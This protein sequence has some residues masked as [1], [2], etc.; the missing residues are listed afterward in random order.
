MTPSKNLLFFTV[1]FSW[2]AR[3]TL[4][5]ILNNKSQKKKL[6]ETKQAEASR[7][8]EL[9][10]AK[11]KLFTY[12]THE[13]RTPLT[14]ILGMTR[15]IREK[16]E[17]WLESGTEKI[18]NN[19][20]NP[21]NLVNQMLDLAKLEAGAMPLHIY[22]QDIIM[23]LRYLT[24]SFSSLAISRN[25]Q[26]RFKP[27]TDHFLLDYD[28]DK[29]MHIVSNLLSNALKF[30]QEG[31]IVELKAGVAANEKKEFIIIVTDNGSGI[32]PEHLPHIFDRFY[33]IEEESGQY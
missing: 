5:L 14:I 20:K 22:Q 12:I 31:N 32:N 9:D 26:L 25:I 4:L 30:N 13:F 27:D 23:Q 8:K 17:E 21:L 10:E 7:L 28:A 29:L 11:T 18:R 3:Y 1:N 15:L 33:R 6:A 19:G 16:P 24:D 2:Q